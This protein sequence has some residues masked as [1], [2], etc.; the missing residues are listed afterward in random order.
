MQEA[1]QAEGW[2]PV[3]SHAEL[4]GEVHHYR[5]DCTPLELGL[6]RQGQRTDLFQIVFAQSWLRCTLGGGW[7]KVGQLPDDIAARV[8]KRLRSDGWS[9]AIV[10]VEP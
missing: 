6:L 5:S 1:V 2:V 10:D 4:R 3:A 9:V 8:V 7:A